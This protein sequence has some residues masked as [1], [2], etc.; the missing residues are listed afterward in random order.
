MN[1]IWQITRPIRLQT[2]CIISNKFTNSMFASFL[3]SIFGALRFE[4]RSLDPKP[5]MLPSYTMPLFVIYLLH[6]NT[7]KEYYRIIF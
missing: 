7:I 2:N 6:I 4:L 3:R 5:G 1:R